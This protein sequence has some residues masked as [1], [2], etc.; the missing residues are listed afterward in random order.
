MAIVP[1]GCKY[2]RFHSG[3]LPHALAEK[4]PQN[5]YPFKRRKARVG[6]V[7]ER[8]LHGSSRGMGDLARRR[9]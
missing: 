6:P 5:L 2:D 4:W 3:T 7:R 9:R 1:T 8:A